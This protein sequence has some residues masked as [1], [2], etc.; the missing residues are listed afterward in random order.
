M[1]MKFIYFPILALLICIPQVVGAQVKPG[2]DFPDWKEGYMDIHHISTG[3]GECVFAILPDGTTMMIDAGETGTDSRN[4]KPNASKSAGGWISN[5]ILRMMRPLTDKKLDYIMLSHFHDD[6]MGNVKLTNKKSAEG[7]Y[8]L[9]GITEVGT[10]IPFDKIVDRNYPDYN[11]PRPLREDPDVENYIRFLNWKV[12]KGVKAE[13]FRVGTK[14]QFTLV[15]NAKRYPN[16]E[17]RNI[18]SN[19]Q[20]WTGTHNNTRH[21]FPPLDKLSAEDY[22]EENACSAA[23]RISYGKFDYFNGG[24]LVRTTKPG[25]WKDIEFPVGIA[26]GPVDVCEVNHHG[27]DAMSAAFVRAVAPRV[28]IIQGFALS[29][30]DAIAM[31]T[32]RAKNIYPG[33]RDIFTSHLFDVNKKVLGSTLVNDFKS[34]QGHTVVRVYP[35]GDQYEVY[36]LDDTSENFIIKSSH[37]KYESR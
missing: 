9:T 4:F 15:R 5:Y 18:A 29:H 16:F 20:V 7:D 19:G 6:H 10:L 33:E 26:T 3:R 27:K 25:T 17:I 31:K 28:F 12:G 36:I 23:I 24:D 1:N 14:E 22:P 37:G 32:M 30:P 11:Y 2:D 8:M 35:G 13:Q 34:T 21:H